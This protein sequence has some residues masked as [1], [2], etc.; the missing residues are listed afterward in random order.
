MNLQTRDD[1]R[2]LIITGMGEKSFICGGNINEMAG[3]K[4]AGEASKFIKTM[5]DLTHAIRGIPVPVIARINGYC[6]GGGLEVALSCDMRIASSNA[7]FGMPELRHGLPSILES[8]TL[9]GLIGTGKTAR[10][11]ML[12]EIISAEEAE[13][14]GLVEKVVPASELDSA[15]QKWIQCLADSGPEA[16]RSQKRLHRNWENMPVEQSIRLSMETFATAYHTDEP[17]NRLNAFQNRNKAKK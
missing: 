7:K 1:L 17:Y 10:L 3:L 15:L 8:A 6:L 13:R 11:L 16:E 9:P 2:A 14:W 5:F 4:T 12:G